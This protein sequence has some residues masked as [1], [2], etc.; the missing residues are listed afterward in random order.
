M[1]TA[2]TFVKELNDLLNNEKQED[3]LNHYE[4]KFKRLSETVFSSQGWPN[5]A[6]IEE[7]NNNYEIP[8]ETQALY[9]ELVNRYKFK[10]N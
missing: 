4:F 2:T 3:L 6:E 10:H 7:A 8:I 1:V 5:S 9:N